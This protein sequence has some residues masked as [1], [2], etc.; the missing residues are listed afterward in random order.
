LASI[1]LNT[2]SSLISI[3]NKFF[4]ISFHATWDLTLWAKVRMLSSSS[5][6]FY[7]WTHMQ[8]STL[9]QGLHSQLPWD[10]TFFWNKGI[11]RGKDLKMRSSWI[12]ED[13]KSNVKILYKN[14]KRRWNKADTIWRQRQTGIIF[15][16]PNNIKDC[17][18]LLDAKRERVVMVS[19]L[20]F[21][22]RN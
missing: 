8:R 11:C 17:Q 14:Q 10:V 19:T 20:Q 2:L 5:M 7:P 21:P 22:W 16:K 6:G 13:P 18:H 1:T 9:P 12:R 15:H 3:C 4:I